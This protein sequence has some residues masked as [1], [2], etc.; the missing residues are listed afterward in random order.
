MKLP[1]RVSQSILLLLA[2]LILAACKPPPDPTVR[3]TGATMG[4]SYDL[5][6]VPAPGQ[7]IPADFQTRVEA[8]LVRINKT[9]S[10]YDPDSE[11]S[12]FNQNTKTDWIAV[13][14]ELQ[15]IVSEGL[16]ISE[17]S[18]G[19][20]DITIG[21]LVNLWGFGP[22][23]R[24]DQVPSEADIAQA[25]E[26]VGYWQLSTRKEPPALRKSRSDLY[27]DLSAIAKGYGVDQLAALAETAG[28]NHYLVSI[29]GEIRA[30][31]H[32]GQGQPWTIAIEKPVAGQRAV[33]RL[34]QLGDHSIS[35]SGDYR[36]F[37]EQNGQRY[38][39]IINPRTGR[40]VP[41]T[42]GSVTVITDQSMIADATATA[43]MA[44]GPEFGFQLAVDH[45]L[46]AF[47]ITVGPKEFGER[48]TPEIER[49]L[50]DGT[51]H[52]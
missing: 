47:F 12:R 3:F 13:S 34:I 45:H 49:Y 23:L 1:C 42:L 4:T 32:N 24:R 10:T 20:F 46:A 43:L 14:P 44:A 16:R 37:F 30:K 52:R 29:A 7:S 25:R 36:N 26:R 5:K 33:E 11:L 41:Q 22:A 6:L 19:A 18:N 15:Q 2:V 50:I 21:P 48:Y 38:S 51:Q 28:I 17:L 8:L 9:L 40:P 39:H 27:V 35:T 31:G